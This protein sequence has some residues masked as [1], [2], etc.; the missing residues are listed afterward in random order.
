MLSRYLERLIHEFDLCRTLQFVTTISRDDK[1]DPISVLQG[2]VTG[3]IFLAE[4]NFNFRT[5]LGTV[6]DPAVKGVD[7]AS[8][9]LGSIDRLED[10][11]LEMFAADVLE[12]HRSL[13][14]FRDCTRNLF[15]VTSL[16]QSHLIIKYFR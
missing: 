14:Q 12:D 8:V 2:E 7:I 1:L 13:S 3:L 5:V 4:R 10:L 16:G 11:T 6:L 15:S 9:F